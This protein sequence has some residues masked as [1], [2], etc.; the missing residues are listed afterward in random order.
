VALPFD[1]VKT[2]MQTAEGAAAGDSTLAA[3][4]RMLRDGGV[5]ALYRGWP[6][7][8][9]RGIPGAALTLTTYDYV[10]RWLD[11]GGQGGM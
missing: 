8:L 3:A 11:G 5:A 2:V 4:A 9:G 1:G 7:A 10:M 6:V